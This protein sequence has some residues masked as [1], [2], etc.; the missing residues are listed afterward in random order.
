MVATGSTNLSASAGGRVEVKVG[1]EAAVS[2]LPTGWLCPLEF[3]PPVGRKIQLLTYTGI[4]VYGHWSWDG[5]YIAWAPCLKIPERFR[6]RIGQF[7]NWDAI[8]YNYS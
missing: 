1:Q 3:R 7:V 5:S 2:D 6:K 4:A 8:R